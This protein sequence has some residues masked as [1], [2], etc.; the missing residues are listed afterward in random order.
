MIP[1]DRASP[2]TEISP[3]SYFFCKKFDVFMPA[4]LPR[5]RFQRPRSRESGTKISSYE[6]GIPV[7]GMKSITKHSRLRTDIFDYYGSFLRCS[8]SK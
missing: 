7:T 3:H 5:S 2:L 6:H 4:R 8:S 1:V